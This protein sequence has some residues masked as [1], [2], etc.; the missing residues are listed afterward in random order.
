MPIYIILLALIGFWFSQSIHILDEQERGVVL[1][2]GVYHST[3]Q[4]GFNFQPA[5]VDT[6]EVVN[7]TAEQQYDPALRDSLMLTQDENIVVVP[8]TV[9]YLSLIH[10]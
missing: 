1:R 9:Q 8:L 4:P 6:V 2:L 7:V 10:I 5:L 3:L